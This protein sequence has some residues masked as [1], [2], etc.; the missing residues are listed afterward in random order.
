MPIAHRSAGLLEIPG[1]LEIV[2]QSD[3]EP[4][5]ITGAISQLVG[6]GD[7]LRR[8]GRLPRIAVRTTQERICHRELGIDFNG[9]LQ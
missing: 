1:H 5:P 2:G 6:L 3:E 8:L 4:L 7:I 9:A